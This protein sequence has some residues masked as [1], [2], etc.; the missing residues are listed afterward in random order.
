MSKVIVLHK[1]FADTYPVTAAV[2][3][4]GWLPGVGFQLNS[5]GDYA[6]LASVDGTMFI[7]ID[8]D[9]EVSTPPTGSLLAGIYGSGTKFIID[10]SIEVAAGSASRAYE[11]DV[12]TASP[13]ANLYISTTGTWQAAATG[14]VKGKLFQVPSAA[15][16]FGL[17]V[18]L[19]F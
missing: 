18:I 1:Q 10:H 11:S 19:R 15:N 12:L 8:D 13:N 17:G 9:L 7:G 14:S 16:N 6:T 5:T 3:A 2:V 4:T